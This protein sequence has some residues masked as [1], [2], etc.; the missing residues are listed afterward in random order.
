MSIFVS[1]NF[2]QLTCFQPEVHW[3]VPTRDDFHQRSWKFNVE[4]LCG[5]YVPS[6]INQFFITQLLVTD[7]SN[8]QKGV[9]KWEH[10][11]MIKLK[12]T[13]W[14]RHC[15]SKLRDQR[16][17]ELVQRGG[18]RN[19]DWIENITRLWMP[20]ANWNETRKKIQYNL[21]LINMNMTE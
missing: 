1:I 4:N 12:Q 11:T 5:G 13:I 17:W 2:Q 15:F 19:S 6:I 10:S 8:V 7:N 14:Y 21:L 9:Y 18:R 20:T 16:E 3:K